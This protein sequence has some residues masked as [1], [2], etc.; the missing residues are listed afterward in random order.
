MLRDQVAEEQG[1]TLEISPQGIAL[2]GHD[3]AGAFY[4]VCTLNQLIRQ[5]G[6]TLPALGIADYPDYAARGI[7]LDVSRCKV[8]TLDTLFE[9]VDLLAKQLGGGVVMQWDNGAD[10]TARFPLDVR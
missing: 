8:P 9:L 7:M 5:F 6:A 3:L 2:T 10:V 1:Y 4:G